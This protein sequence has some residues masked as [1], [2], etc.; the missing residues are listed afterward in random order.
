MRIHTNAQTLPAPPDA[1][2]SLHILGTFGSR[3]H[4][5]AFEVTL[6]GHGTRHKR[7]P[8]TPLPDSDRAGE[9]AATYDDWGRWLA[10]VFDAD[11]QAKTAPY[12]DR[13][14]FHTKTDYAYG[15]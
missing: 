4:A 1:G 11:P 5:R 6:R 9:R 2:V 14:D 8:H 15:Y 13:D 3:S 12:A 10:L 7:S